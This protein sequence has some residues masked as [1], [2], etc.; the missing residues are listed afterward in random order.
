VATAYDRRG[1]TRCRHSWCFGCAAQG[2]SYFSGSIN[3]IQRDADG[4]YLAV[5]ARGNFYLTCVRPLGAR[6]IPH[7]HGSRDPRVHSGRASDRVTRGA[8]LCHGGRYKPGDEFWIPHNRETSRRI[9]S[10]GFVKV[11]V[12]ACSCMSAGRERVPVVSPLPTLARQ[13]GV[14]QDRLVDGL[15]MSTVRHTPDGTMAFRGRS[16][17]RLHGAT[18][19]SHNC[20]EVVP[21]P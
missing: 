12:C 10:M 15:W 18:G 13:R 6:P 2:A 7:Q 14:A 5:S 16:L 3:S 20:A 11:R 9:T 8:P 21:Y 17:S 1:V 19:R 4:S